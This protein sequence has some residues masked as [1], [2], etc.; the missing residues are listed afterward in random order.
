M[1]YLP[2]A[3][4]LK[5]FQRKARS[6][7]TSC[8]EKLHRNKEGVI[9]SSVEFLSSVLDAELTPSLKK[10]SSAS[11]FFL[12]DSSCQKTQQNPRHCASSTATNIRRSKVHN[13]PAR[14]L[15]ADDRLGPS[16]GLGLVFETLVQE[17]EDFCNACLKE[18]EPHTHDDFLRWFP[19][20]ANSLCAPLHVKSPLPSLST[21]SEDE[22]CDNSAA[23]EATPFFETQFG[24]DKL[25]GSRFGFPWTSPAL[26]SRFADKSSDV[27]KMWPGRQKELL[28]ALEVGSLALDV[29]ARNGVACTGNAN[30]E[31][32]LWDFGCKA[33]SKASMSS[34]PQPVVAMSINPDQGATV[35]G[36]SKGLGIWDQR[37]SICMPL[38]CG[39]AIS[40]KNI[41]IS[42]LKSRGNGLCIAHTDS[43]LSMY[44]LR[45]PR[46]KALYRGPSANRVVALPDSDDEADADLL[47]KLTCDDDDDF[48]DEF[49]GAATGNGSELQKGDSLLS[50]FASF[51]RVLS[52]PV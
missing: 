51:M 6:K 11:K 12:G 23:I 1:P 52:T 34:F 20:W 13:L 44:D 39:S 30:G 22:D 14:M 8:L 4:S 9:R 26:C 41:T 16:L 38:R 25:L 46:S 31:I 50:R 37:S 15:D 7:S 40:T 43:T 3:S 24:W 35:V 47:E 21:Y 5:S 48:W 18:E 19:S 32:S 28:R 36:S 45:M 10:I 17:N 27:V 49:S 33:Y 42:D 2:L 29:S